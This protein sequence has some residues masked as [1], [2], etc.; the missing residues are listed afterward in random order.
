[1]S[2]ECAVASGGNGGAQGDGRD[3][4]GFGPAGKVRSL[5]LSEIGAETLG[6]A[7]T[8]QAAALLSDDARRQVSNSLFEPGSVNRAC[9]PDAECAGIEPAFST[10][11]GPLLASKLPQQLRV[12][13]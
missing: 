3:H 2:A 10:W 1:M 12:T 13:A 5:G 4:G 9:R 7:H 8:V 11:A 6:A